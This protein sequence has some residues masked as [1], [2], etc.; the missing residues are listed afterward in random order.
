MRASLIAA[1][2]LVELGVVRDLRE[3]EVEDVDAV[4]LGRRAEPD[5]AAH[6]RA[7]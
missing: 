6:V 1:A 3:V 7:A 2:R 4:L 5:V